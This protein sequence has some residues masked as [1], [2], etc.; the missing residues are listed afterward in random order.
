MPANHARAEPPMTRT[1]LEERSA[2]FTRL[3]TLLFILIC[4]LAGLAGSFATFCISGVLLLGIVPPLLVL[5]ETA[6]NWMA[7]LVLLMTMVG[8]L[9]PILLLWRQ[10]KRGLPTHIQRQ[11]PLPVDAPSGAEI[12]PNSSQSVNRESYPQSLET[13]TVSQV[14][15]PDHNGIERIPHAPYFACRTRW[16]ISKHERTLE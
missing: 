8:F 15:G 12:V 1:S 7:A 2:L 9:A 10:R 16:A 14:I 6:K 13:Q 3:P 11:R 5:G 4:I